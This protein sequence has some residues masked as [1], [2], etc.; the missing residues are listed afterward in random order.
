MSRRDFAKMR[1]RQNMARRG[2]EQVDGG[3]FTFGAPCRSKSKADERKEAAGLLSP[4]TMITK[5]ITC[6]CGHKGKVRVP[7]A[8]AGGPFRCVSCGKQKH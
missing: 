1:T 5:N 8:K 6:P 7:L 3:N 4:S 2:S